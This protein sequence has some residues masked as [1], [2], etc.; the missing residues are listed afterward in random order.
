MA[1]IYKN[2]IL[3][4]PRQAARLQG[5][6]GDAVARWCGGE[7]I[8]GPTVDG[9]VDVQKHVVMVPTLEGTKLCAFGGWVIKNE[10]GRFTVI[11][12]KTF[13]EVYTEGPVQPA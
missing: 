4:Q 10:R 6:T 7:Y 8:P 11:E 2:Y 12:N 5:S 9:V 3:K 1:E 13:Q